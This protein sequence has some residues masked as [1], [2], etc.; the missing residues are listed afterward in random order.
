MAGAAWG[1]VL[2]GIGLFLLGMGLMTDSLTALGG[3]TLRGWI[4]S[5]TRNRFLGLLTGAGTTA[6]VQSSSA[7][8]LVTV[9]FVS[10]G[11]LSFQQSLGVILGANVGTT[12]TAWIVSLVG[13]KLDVS[14]FALPI[15][16]V[17][18]LVRLFTRGR[19]ARLGMAMAGFGLLFVGID[20][21]Q[22]GM[23]NL[24]IDLTPFA[25][26]GGVLNVLAL[27]AVGALMTVVMQ[28]SSAAVATTLAAMHAGTLSLDQ[29]AVLVIGQNV[30][31]T[32]T[33]IIGAIGG[34]TAARRAAGA[35]TMFNLCAGGIALLV[36][37]PFLMGVE[38]TGRWIGEPTPEVMLA[39]FHT[40]FNLLGV[41]LVLPVLGPFA[42]LVERLIPE[43]GGEVLQGLSESALQM[44]TL[45]LETARRTTIELASD[46][47]FELSEALR[48]VAVPPERRERLLQTAAG[49]VRD[50]RRL[51]KGT[52]A[53]AIEATER[54][55]RMKLDLEHIRGYV[56]R[57]R[58]APGQAHD[59]A[60]HVELLHAL[61]RLHR[62]VQACDD[63]SAF[64]RLGRSSTLRALTHEIAAQLASASTELEALLEALPE[65]AT[66]TVLA[67][68]ARLDAEVE[69]L[70]AEYRTRILGQA[71]Q[72]DLD[73]AE[74][75]EILEAGRWL[76]RLTLHAWRAT[77][78]LTWPGGT[79]TPE[80]T[81]ELDPD[82]D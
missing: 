3:R 20:V 23:A 11:I 37:R 82:F 7:T 73:A 80:A 14:T 33:A 36:L 22:D 55:S 51:L 31:T 9:G 30:G 66:P 16:G 46:T 57:V 65:D 15:V 19:R 25:Q 74:A 67:R 43:R 77:T 8:T 34:S 61:G 40:A 27:V 69:R 29:G 48:S 41:A 54:L 12:S 6:V 81:S 71:A 4:R 53:K 45:A 59:H 28:S 42:R 49:V 52:D 13:L 60:E 44:P 76:R 79:T 18:A 70:R 2:G 78:H 39:L 62:L 32:V 38:A 50:P 63:P 35:H 72:G 56:T 75:D 47:L 5:M 1:T 64:E 26:G 10:A 58:T 17:G 21:L 68:L 24:Q